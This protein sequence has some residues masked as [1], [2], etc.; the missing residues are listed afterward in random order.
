MG[1]FDKFKR[2]DKNPNEI[3]PYT[4]NRPEQE[5]YGPDG[6][7]SVKNASYSYGG[8]NSYGSDDMFAGKTFNFNTDK[9]NSEIDE[10]TGL[11][12]GFLSRMED[13]KRKKEEESRYNSNQDVSHNPLTDSS[14]TPKKIIQSNAETFS[15]YDSKIDKSLLSNNSENKKLSDYDLAMGRGSADSLRAPNIIH[16]VILPLRG[17]SDKN[18][19]PMLSTEK[20]ITKSNPY[21]T[22]DINSNNHNPLLGTGKA[23]DYKSV[24]PKLDG[25]TANNN[26]LYQ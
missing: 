1:L 22:G 17:D 7:D 12:Q 8:T 25:N 14:M 23:L 18:Y 3:P 10:E 20:P 15:Q 6:L 24:S 5:Y 2:T 19:N 11:T 9:K 4:I 16:P 13:E 21:E 26:P